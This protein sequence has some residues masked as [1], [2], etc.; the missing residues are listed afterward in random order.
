MRTALHR[1]VTSLALFGLVSGCGAD[2][3]VTGDDAYATAGATR[4]VKS[5]EGPGNLVVVG[6][7]LVFS[8]AHFDASGDPEL[9][10]QFASWRGTVWKR[11]LAGGT[12]TKVH[13]TVGAVLSTAQI[14]KS[15]LVVDSGYFGVTK[16]TFPGGKETDFYNDFSHFP[17]EAEELP[18]LGGVAVGESGVY[19]TR[20]GSE[21]LHMGTDGSNVT[22]FAETWKSGWAEAAETRRARPVLRS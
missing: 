6:D 18:S 1:A 16:L 21:V 17:D 5:L 20:P 14:G 9:D 7:Q 3:V 15:L 11:P 10:Q 12:K 2:D 22:T 8:T 4:I 13:D 19:V